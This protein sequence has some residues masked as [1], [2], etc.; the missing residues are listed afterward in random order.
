MAHQT[1]FRLVKHRKSRAVHA[2]RHPAAGRTADHRRITSPVDED[3]HLTARFDSLRHRLLDLFGKDGRL[4]LGH[5][6]ELHV[7]QMSAC[8]RTARQRQPLVLTDAHLL[9][10]FKRRRRRPQHTGNLVVKGPLK[11]YVA[12]RKPHSL[13]SLV[14]R[15]VLFVDDDERKF[16][17]A[18]KDGHARSDQNA[19]PTFVHGKP[20]ARSLCRRQARVHRHDG[21]LSK[22][23]PHAGFKLRCQIDF[24]HQKHHLRLRILGQHA[25]DDVQVNLCLSGT[26]HAEEQKRCVAGA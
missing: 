3:Q 21:G 13:S 24:R 9:P 5:I 7:G 6:D 10:G 22:T 14:A 8:H 4:A 26:S 18:R 1:L 11:R 25:F 16:L 23:C 12:S 20:V 2:P 17:K 19:C 15:V